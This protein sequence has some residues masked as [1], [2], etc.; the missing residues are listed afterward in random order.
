[1]GASILAGSVGLSTGLAAERR[2]VDAPDTKIAVV[3][4]PTESPRYL[5][6]EHQSTQ[7]SI[8]VAGHPLAY[9]A[10]AG[11]LVVHV[12]DP[13]DD[14]APLPKDER[15]G[16][17]PPQPP[18]ASMSYV[19]YFKGDKEDT[20]SAHHVRGSTADRVHRRYGCTWARSARSGW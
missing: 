5:H 20:P 2:P 18:E 13:L 4:E 16:P 6:D 14:D 12:R 3:P 9:Q 7:G 8:V 11:V 15:T 19:A 1:M 10:E 17:P